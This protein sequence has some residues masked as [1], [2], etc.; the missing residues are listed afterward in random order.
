MNQVINAAELGLIMINGLWKYTE[1][2]AKK[3][4][5]DT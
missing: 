4:N 5:V 3:Y 1:T 2:D